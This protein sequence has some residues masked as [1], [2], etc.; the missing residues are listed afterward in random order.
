MNLVVK[1]ASD[2]EGLVRAI[3]DQVYAVDR[4]QPVYKIRTM[5][6]VVAD[7]QSSP[8]MTLALLAVFAGMALLMAAVGIYGVLS[9]VVVQRTREIGIRVAIGAPGSQVVSL[10]L[11]QGLR[12]TAYGVAIGLAVAAVLT[13]WMASLLYGVSA[14]DPLIFA[15]V[16][17]LMAAVA[18]AACWLPALR[19]VHLDPLEALRCD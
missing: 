19:A 8:R 18:C 15:G 9:Y 17:S 14:T 7:S 4:D 3:K 13:R 5:E 6:R 16:A 2:P 1:T 11:A 10:I 12:L